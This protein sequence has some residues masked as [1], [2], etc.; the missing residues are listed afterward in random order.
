MMKAIIRSI[1]K[2]ILKIM[3]ADLYQQLIDWIM[4]LN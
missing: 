3:I 4:N 2:F 1:L